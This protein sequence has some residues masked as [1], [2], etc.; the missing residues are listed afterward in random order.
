M[1]VEEKDPGTPPRQSTWKTEL[2]ENLLTAVIALV[3]AF[4]IRTFVAEPRYIPSD[5]MLPTLEEGDRIAV[6]KISYRWRAPKT[7]DIVVFRPPQ[8]LQ[9]YGYGDNQAFIKRIVGAPGQTIAVRNGRVYINST[10]LPEDYIAEPPSYHLDPVTVPSD[11]FF[12]M[13]DNRNNSNDSHVWGFLPSKNI[14]GRACFRFW[15]FA[16][17]GQI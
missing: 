13:G 1:T 4:S 3:V 17:V 11:R 6:E 2:R 5:S 8:Q 14:I 10:P 12:V 7:G 16:R 9:Q 15:P